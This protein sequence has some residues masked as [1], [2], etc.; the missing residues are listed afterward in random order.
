MKL[1]DKGFSTEK[2]IEWFTV[3]NDRE[4]DLVLARYDV[5]GSEAH[6]KMLADMGVFSPDECKAIL[7]ELSHIATQ[8]DNGAFTIEPSFEDVHSKI[9]YLLTEKLGD[10]GKKNSYCPFPKRSDFGG[11]APVFQK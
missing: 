5:M 9:E 6:V 1:W 10:T 4:L 7:G 11:Y 3:G 8:I 2:K